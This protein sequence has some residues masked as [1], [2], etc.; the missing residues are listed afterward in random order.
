MCI[1]LNHILM[2]LPK[3]FPGIIAFLAVL[4]T[5]PLGHSA[6][7]MMEHLLGHTYVFHAAVLLGLLGVM[8][9]VAGTLLAHDT[10]ATL[11]GL[12]GGLF[13]WTGWIE[14]SFVYYAHRYQIPPLMEDG[15]VATKPE[16]LLM[17]S[18]VG[19][20]VVFLLFYLFY[21]RTG[22]TFFSWLQRHL[23]LRQTFSPA[24]APRHHP[25]LAT[26]I[27]LIVLVWT[28]YLVLLF[29]YDEAFFGDRHPV[30][31]LIAFGSLFWAL[32]LIRKLLRITQLGYAIRYS[33]PTVVI[34]WNFVEVMGRWDLLQEIWIEP[35]HYWRE[36]SAMVGVLVIL[37]VI[38]WWERM[39]QRPARA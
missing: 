10:R 15:A 5:M 35:L 11:L 31:Y 12:F 16:Y 19:F 30:T 20:L 38:A 2:Q 27:E 6:M 25:A 33:I 13:I 37:T 34:F 36:V 32:Y 7:I 29:A 26:A 14:F 28:F 23:K 1:S 4:A 8:L 3:P 22:C 24:K 9:V 21:S 39:R 17:P 18:S